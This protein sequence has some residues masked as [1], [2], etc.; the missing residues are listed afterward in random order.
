MQSPSNTDEGYLVEFKEFL[1]QPLTVIVGRQNLRYGNGLIIGDP[2]TD[3]TASG[4]V[5]VAISDLSLRKSFDAVRGIFDFAP[6]TIDVRDLHR[7][8][9]VPV[10]R[11]DV[12]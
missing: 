9:G 6:W 5:P 1:Y 3:Q 12:G 7:L 10:H 8:C 4:K 11:G 2:D